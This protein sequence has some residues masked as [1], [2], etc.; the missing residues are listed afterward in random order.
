M[1]ISRTSSRFGKRPRRDT[2]F[3]SFFADANEGLSR[4]TLLQRLGRPADFFP[5]GAVSLNTADSGSLANKNL[6]RTLYGE[7][8][9]S[10]SR[11]PLSAVETARSYLAVG[12]SVDRHDG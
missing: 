8:E 12:L 2:T 11:P 4:A 10:F 5:N 9:S 3:S 7:Q 1:P 6:V